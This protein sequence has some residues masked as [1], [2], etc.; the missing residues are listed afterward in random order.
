MG[1][2]SR[3]FGKSETTQ[4]SGTSS[5]SNPAPWF[6]NWFNGGAESSSGI[7]VS[8][9]RALCDPTVLTCVSIRAGDLAKLPAHVYRIK[10]DGGR[11]IVTNHPLEKLL[12]RPNDWQTRLEFVE[13]MQMAVLLR[14]N[15]YA[16]IIR[17]QRGDPLSFVPI[18][19]MTMQVSDDGDIFYGWRS[20]HQHD[21]AVLRGVQNPVPAADVL[22]IRG[23]SKNGLIGLSR[24]HNGRDTV[25]LSIA[26]E[27][28]SSRLFSQGARPGGVLYTDGKLDD[29]AFA[30]IRAQW[31]GYSGS[32]NSGKTPI[33]ENG[34]KWQAQTM[35]SVESQTIEARKMQIQLIAMLLDIPLHRIGQAADG[36]V[37]NAI[38]ESNQQYLNNTLSG[39]AERWETKLAWLFGLPAGYEVKFDL[40]YFNRADLATRLTAYRTGVVGMIYTPNEVRRLEGLPAVDGGD[41]LYQPTNVAPI[42]FIPNQGGGNPSGP[43]SDV[44]G[45]P[46]QGGD[47]DPTAVPPVKRF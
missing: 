10:P 14:G 2:L 32:D 6:L 43:G 5:S 46:G 28:H 13:Q 3:L 7:V 19:Q 34:L 37:G 42:G 30:R 15:A 11:E 41:T 17:N 18:E 35:T 8:E 9:T 1:L 23:I 47:G 24:L 27:E 45:E 12:Q 29:S 40:D 44:T 39:D 36:R 26:L 38:I 31:S 22:H 21:L 25:G 16:V 4:K 33:L 20:A